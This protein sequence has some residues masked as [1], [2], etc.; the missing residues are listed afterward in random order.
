MLSDKQLCMNKESKE[1]YNFSGNLE[2]DYRYGLGVFEDCFGVISIHKID[3]FEPLDD[4]NAKEVD[5][6]MFDILHE[7]RMEEK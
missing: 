3:D 4:E 6:I 1:L 2:G 7:L 5:P